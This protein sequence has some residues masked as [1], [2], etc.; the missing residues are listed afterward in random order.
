MTASIY[1]E[2]SKLIKKLQLLTLKSESISLTQLNKQESHQH[3]MMCSTSP[4]LG[5]KLNFYSD[6]N[7][8]VWSYFQS[9][10][11]QQGYQG[12]L[13]GGFLY[14]LLDSSM[15]QALFNKDIEAVTADMNIQFLHE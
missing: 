5:F 9:S 13:H 8:L 12:I 2:E 3:C 1:S 15:C 11:H 10:K 4:L 6:H 14:A 7:Q